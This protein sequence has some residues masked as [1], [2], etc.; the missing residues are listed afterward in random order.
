VSGASEPAPFDLDGG[1]GADWRRRVVDRSLRSAA[2]RSVDRGQALIRAAGAVLDRNGGDD[3]TV[4]AVADEAGQSL[5]T[6]YQY[7]SSKD[8]LLLGV[9]EEAM[10]TYARLIWR[11]IEPLDDPLERLAGALVAAIRMPEFTGGGMDRGLARLRLRLAETEPDRV[12]RAQSALVV[13]LRSLVEAAAA[14]GSIE[15]DD[16]DATTFLLLSVNAAHITAGTLGNDAGV[17]RPEE[18]AAVE[19]CMRGLGADV[20]VAWLQKLDARLVLPNRTV[21]MKPKAK[22]KPKPKK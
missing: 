10:R 7:F 21:A 5:R 1:E 2:E 11:A 16:T 9:F 13:L 19:F 6:L 17:S 15:V 4:Q 20:D 3:I 8:D 22:I 18:H 12:G 14:S